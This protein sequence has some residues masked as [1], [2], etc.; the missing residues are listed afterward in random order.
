MN[1]PRVQLMAAQQAANEQLQAKAQWSQAVQRAYT[2]TLKNL[3][4]STQQRNFTPTYLPSSPCLM[5][6]R[7]ISLNE[8]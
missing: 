1:R 5:A 3:A 2:N 6:L 8:D 4:K 7:K